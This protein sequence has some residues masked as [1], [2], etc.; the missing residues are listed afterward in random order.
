M[1]GNGARFGRVGCKWT[2]VDGRLCLGCTRVGGCRV[3]VLQ[4]C[5]E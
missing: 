1:R 2:V 5:G 3:W 4:A